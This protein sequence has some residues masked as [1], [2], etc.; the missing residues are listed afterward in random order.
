MPTVFRVGGYRFFFFSNERT[1][2]PHIHVQRAEQYA[3][4]WLTPVRLAAN[5]GYT[6]R[7]ITRLGELIEQH[8]DL[9]LEAWRE[10]FIS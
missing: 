6:S 4:F 7:E 5:H 2:L 10:H 1:E 8:R 9:L 3:K